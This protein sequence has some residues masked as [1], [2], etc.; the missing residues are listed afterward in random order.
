MD[1]YYTEMNEASYKLALENPALLT[2]KEKLIK[3]ARKTVHDKG[4][5]YKKKATRSKEFGNAACTDKRPYTTKDL[6]NKRITE[7][8]EDIE[9]VN[10]QT[11]PLVRQREKHVNVNQFGL[12]ANITEQVSQLRAKKRKLDEELTLILQKQKECKRQKKRSLSAP[13]QLTCNTITGYPSSSKKDSDV[14][15][16]NTTPET[17]TTDTVISDKNVSC[18]SS[19]QNDACNDCDESCDNPFLV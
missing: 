18:T 12:A 2:D 8:Q 3:L 17:S 15:P 5:S 9:D 10:T 13:Q 11:A 19:D 6:K 14:I 4:Y 1:A 16:A 7:I